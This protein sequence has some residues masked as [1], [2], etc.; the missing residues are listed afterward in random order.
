MQASY[1]LKIENKSQGENNDV[2]GNNESQSKGPYKRTDAIMG[3]SKVHSDIP[4][5]VWQSRYIT[6]SHHAGIRFFSP[7]S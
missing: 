1:L 4:G 2:P 5:P 7:E 3:Q 6:L